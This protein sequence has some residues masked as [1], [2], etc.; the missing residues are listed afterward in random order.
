[1]AQPS[2]G[3]CVWLTSCLE[4]T[5]AVCESKIPQVQAMECQHLLSTS[6][7][8]SASLVHPTSTIFPYS[9]PGSSTS[10]DVTVWKWCLAL[11]DFPCLCVLCS[12][13]IIKL[14]NSIYLRCHSNIN[15][16][17]HLERVCC[18]L[19]KLL[20]TK[21]KLWN[22]RKIGIDTTST[23]SKLVISQVMRPK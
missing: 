16:M 4:S 7:A 2:S 8:F 10:Q 11:I 23:D 13:P 12:H 5:F 15:A 1:M 6:A 14:W 17:F 22:L 19:F 3:G 9:W 18:I 21:K 20:L